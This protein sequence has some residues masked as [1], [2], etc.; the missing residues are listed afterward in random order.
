MF[1]RRSDLPFER[2]DHSRFLPWLIAFMVFLA[3][4]SLAGMLLL[5]ATAKKW[6]NGVS[7][8]LTIQISPSDDPKDDEIRTAE[9]LRILKTVPEITFFE[10]LTTEELLVLLEPWLGTGM[11]DID[12]PLPRLISVEYDEDGGVDV[13]GL[14]RKL[15]SR[16]PGVTVDDHRVWL[17]RFVRLIRMIE[18][19][20]TAVLI[21]ISLATV[22]TVVFTTRTGLAIHREGIEVLHLIGARDSYIATQFATHAGT[23]GVRGGLMGM[24]LAIPTVMGMGSLADG[25]EANMLPELNLT[26]V[27]WVILA[28]LPLIVSI[29]ARMTARITVMRMLHK[30]Q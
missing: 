5:H 3:V 28:S 24:A 17:D 30:M 9:V 18:A 16:V 27:H 21:F 26:V 6:D 15:S 19:V 20:A 13:E 4:L 12:L 23:L 1:N 14:T 7:G 25:M 2:D 29:I 22:G 8:T 11:N 10:A